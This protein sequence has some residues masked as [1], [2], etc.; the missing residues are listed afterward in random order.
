MSTE[1]TAFMRDLE[2]RFKDATQLPDRSRYKIFYGQIHPAPILSL[3]INPGGSPDDISSDGKTHRNGAIAAASA[4]YYE[5]GDHDILDCEWREN[6]GLRRLLGSL[7]DGD[8]ARIRTEVVKSNMAFRRSAKTSHINV[9]AAMTETAPFLAEII[10]VVS[11]KLVLLTGPSLAI[12]TS[13]FA[14][15]TTVVAPPEKDDKIK[16]TV[17]AAARALLGSRVNEALIVQVAHASQF[18]W[19]Y[20]RYGVAEKILALLQRT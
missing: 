16:Q 17:F 20:E 11:P 15:R 10:E 9:Q 5:Q 2:R 4:S 18:S 13:T 14:I 7:L 6:K 8:V 3:G 1:S 12:F 19:T